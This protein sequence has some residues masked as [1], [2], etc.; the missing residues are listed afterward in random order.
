MASLR[1]AAASD[2]ATLDWALLKVGILAPADLAPIRA[3][4]ARPSATLRASANRDGH[5]VVDV[6][7]CGQ[8]VARIH[9]DGTVSPT[10]MV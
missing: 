5:R 3:V 2:D 1:A 10:A 6:I 9:P 4:L 7:E 8:T